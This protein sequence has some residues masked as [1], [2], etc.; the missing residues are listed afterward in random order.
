MQRSEELRIVAIVQARM[1]SKRLPGKVLAD[2]EGQP[3]LARVVERSSRAG[4]LHEVVVATTLEGEDDSVAALCHDRSYPF[5]RGHPTDV[6]DRYLRAAQAHSADVIVRITGD[7]PLIDAEVIDMTVAALMADPGQVDYA[8]N[9]IEPTFPIGLDV[10]VMTIEALKRAER[11][12]QELH[13]REH[14]TPYFY[15]NPDKF[16]IVSVTSGADHGRLRW[17]VDTEEDLKFVRAI[18]SRFDGSSVFGW[19]DVLSLLGKEPDLS[20][21]N[22]HVRQ[23]SYREVG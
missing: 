23:K 2:I 12:G 19:K 11:E 16:N 17:T 20:S 3:M 5:S 6:L 9:R 8:S 22:A 1:G 10:E 13:Q 18:Y 21:I 14:V 7:C 15:E 4:T